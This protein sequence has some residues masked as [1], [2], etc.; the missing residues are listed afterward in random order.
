MYSWNT[1]DLATGDYFL[2]LIAINDC[3]LETVTTTIVYIDND[4]DTVEIRSPVEDQVVGGAVCIDGTVWDHCG[5]GAG[6]YQVLYGVPDAPVPTG[7]VDP[8]IDSY[9]AVVLND[10]L[11]PP[12]P[13]ITNSGAAA[14]A[15]GEWRIGVLAE[16]ACGHTELV[17]RDVI[18]DNTPPDAELTSPAPCTVTCGDIEIRGT[19]DDL[20]FG[21]WYVEYTGG[22]AAGWMPLAEGDAPVNNGLFWTWD[23]SGLRRCAYTIRLRVYDTA[24]VNCDDNNYREYTVSIDLRAPGDFNLDGVV[25]SQDYFDFL[26][27]FFAIP[28]C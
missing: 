21:H 27:A 25:N 28:P 15:D 11:T 13:W 19:A 26:S 14:V 20:H 2:R 16:D 18:I 23:T 17:F 6:G 24:V 8:D 7:T 22:D 12:R 4:F 5:L 3:A 1:A 9:P 10:P